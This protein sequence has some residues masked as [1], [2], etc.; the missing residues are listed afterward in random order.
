MK[1]IDIAIASRYE[2]IAMNEHAATKDDASVRIAELESMLAAERALLTAERA[3]AADLEQERDRLRASHERLRIELELLKRRIF[4]ASAERFDTKQLEMEFEQKLRELDTM[5]GT[6]G[7]PAEDDEGDGTPRTR[8]KPKGRRSLRNLKVPVERFEISDPEL[9]AL[10]AA[11]KVVRHG[12]EESEQLAYRRGGPILLVRARVK[13]KTVHADGSTDVITTPAP[14][15]LLPRSI[16][17]PSMLARTINDR[18]CDGLPLFR[19]EERFSRETTPIDRGSMSRWHEHLGATFGATIIE[20]MRIDALATA[21]C[22][23]TDAS[24][25]SIQPPRMP[26]RLE[27]QPCRKGHY[28][29]QIADRDHV[30]FEYLERETS[31]A[32]GDLFKGFSGYV[33]ADAKSV[34]DALF[35]PPKSEDDDERHEIACWSHFRRKFW[36][37]AIAKSV[38]G[39]EGL[40]RIGRIFEL[41]MTWKDKPPDEIK[42]LREAHLRPHV[43]ALFEWIEVEEAKVHDQRGLVRSA[44]GYGNRQKKALMRFL[45]DGRLVLDNN[46]SERALRKLA[47]G[48]KNWLFAGSNDHAQSTANLFTLVAS[49]RLH[50]LDPERYLRDVIY[51]LPFWPRDRYLELAPKYW[52]ATRARLDPRELDSECLPLTVPPPVAG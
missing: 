10:V 14:P 11:G 15:Q 35:E 22:I 40:A 6:L 42:R 38:V 5:A 7:M 48:R 23:S 16:A 47:V 19:Q 39:R 18:I 17:A 52:A 1:R 4:V 43:E 2:E 41:D 34:F 50:G 29:V 31:D 26:G 28:L 36:E 21:F 27:R 32:I 13:Y 30:F 44:L 12:F 25:I 33:Q 24:G 20:A 46:R 45:E 49:A 37:A 9:E 3:R 51:V 8:H